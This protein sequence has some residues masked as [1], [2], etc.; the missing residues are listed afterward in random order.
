MVW[1][2][3]R[4]MPTSMDILHLT[5]FSACSDAAFRWAIALAHGNQAKLSVLHVVVPDALTYMAPDS[6]TAL[7]IQ[8]NRARG[9]MQKVDEQLT[10]LPH[11]TIVR[12]GT[13]VWTAV[14]KE[15]QELQSELI[16]LGTHGRIG[17]TKLLLGSVAERALRHSP[18]PVIS[19]GPGVAQGPEADGKFHR[20][21]LATDFSPGSAAA[22]EYALSLAQRDQAE[23]VLLHACKT[24]KRSKSNKFSEL[25]VAEALHRLHELVRHAASTLRGHPETL[26]EFGNAGTQILEVARR[27]EADLIVMGLRKGGSVLAATHLEIGTTHKV[28]AHAPCPV[29]TVRPM[30]CQAA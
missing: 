9:Q 30:A 26:V 18:V 24:G 21:L 13:D 7:D 27:K 23:L 8:E 5:D 28:V 4:R 11:D 2:T 17:F 14:Q 19:V 6:A 1:T 22:A 25:S 20:V 12:R 29:L 3:T 15:L 10:S 16:V